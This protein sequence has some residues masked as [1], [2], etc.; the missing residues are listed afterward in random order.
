MN[1]PDYFAFFDLDRTLSGTISGKEMVKSAYKKG[2]MKTRDLLYAIYLSLGYK[3]NLKDP[4]RIIDDMA[5]WVK[6]IPE[7]T[8]NDLLSEVFSDA[9]LP[10]LFPDAENEIKSHKEK[11]AGLV[12][13]SSSLRPLC[14]KVADHFGMD[15]VICSDLETRDGLYTGH[16]LGAN[17]FGEEKAVR[18]K[19][20]CEIN[21]STPELSWYYG[22]S[23]SDLHAL[24]IVGNP[25]CV[26]PDRLLLKVAL[27]KGWKIYYWR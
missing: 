3:L 16:Y 22:D 25:V 27:K 8:L 11:N 2:I 21:N 20:Y 15:D 5:G 6:G 24:N 1:R 14:L 12:I 9:V 13:L 17:C 7:N 23:I 26:N 19:K 10:S 18:L 4:Q